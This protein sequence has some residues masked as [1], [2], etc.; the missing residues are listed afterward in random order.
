MVIALI[1]ALALVFLLEVLVPLIVIGIPLLIN[2]C[3]KRRNRK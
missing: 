2:K 1:S 3:K